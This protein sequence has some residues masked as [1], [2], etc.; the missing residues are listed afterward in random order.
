VDISTNGN[1]VSN[2]LIGTNVGGTAALGNHTNGVR[3]SGGAQGNF[4][5]YSNVVSGNTGDGIQL[6][7]GSSNNYVLGNIVGL[8]G[9]KTAKIPNT[10]SGV[11]IASQASGNLVGTGGAGNYISGNTGMAGG[12]YLRSRDE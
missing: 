6:I 11:A 4:I 3:L 1:V 5:G 10:L 7:G 8:N 9:A 12:I 2:N